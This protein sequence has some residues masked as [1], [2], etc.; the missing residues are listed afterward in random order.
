[1]IIWLVLENIYNPS[2][3]LCGG[4]PGGMHEYG[5][6]QPEVHT[7]VTNIHADEHYGLLFM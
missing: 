1:M 4:Q 6:W 7:L 5:A 2:A 3:R